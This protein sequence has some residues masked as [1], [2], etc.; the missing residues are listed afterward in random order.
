MGVIRPNRVVPR[1]K[2]RPFGGGF[3]IVK[4]MEF[5]AISLKCSASSEPQLTSGEIG[6][7]STRRPGPVKLARTSLCL[8][9][10]ATLRNIAPG[11]KLHERAVIFARR[12]D[13]V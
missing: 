2:S 13:A 1:E 10:F 4:F 7:T 6:P 5:E 9:H 11:F 12:S 3:F 8:V